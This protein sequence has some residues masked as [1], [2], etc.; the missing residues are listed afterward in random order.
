MEKITPLDL[1]TLIKKLQH[2]KEKHGG[3]I[4]ITAHLLDRKTFDIREQ[5]INGAIFYEDNIRLDGDDGYKK[6]PKAL[7][8]N[9][10]NYFPAVVT[11]DPCEPMYRVYN[12]SEALKYIERG[13]RL[14]TTAERW[15]S[16]HKVIDEI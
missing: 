8:F 4:L 3:S 16:T 6:I 14:A 11:K 5:Y 9:N 15:N 12:R 13:Y 7:W 1:D 10:E 2:L